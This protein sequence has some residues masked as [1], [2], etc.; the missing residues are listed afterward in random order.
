[1]GCQWVLNQAA[2][3]IVKGYT[4]CLA[5]CMALLTL[6]GSPDVAGLE[7]N[8][9]GPENWSG[10]SDASPSFNP[11]D[12][13]R[14]REVN[15]EHLP[16]RGDFSGVL[17]YTYQNFVSSVDG[18]RCQHYPT[19][20]HFAALALRTK[21]IRSLGWIFD[22]IVPAHG[23]YGYEPVLFKDR[24]YLYDPLKAHE[25]KADS[26][27]ELDILI[28][29]ASE[30]L[31][32]ED[33]SLKI[34]SR[35]SVLHGE[36]T[37]PKLTMNNSVEAEFADHLFESG[38]FYRAITEYRRL[39][40]AHRGQGQ[41]A[42]RYNL[43][44]NEGLWRAKRFEAALVGYTKLN[45]SKLSSQD[46]RATRLAIAK[47]LIAMGQPEKG[48]KIL[49]DNIETFEP[50]TPLM[51]ENLWSLALTLELLSQYDTEHELA[52]LVLSNAS[53]KLALSLETEFNSVRS[54]ELFGER[55]KRRLPAG[56]LAILPGAGYL[57]LNRPKAAL[58][59]LLGTGILG[60]ATVLSGIKQNWG[61]TLVF[62]LATLSFYSATIMGS[63]H[64]ASQF[65]ENLQ[66]RKR[67]YLMEIYPGY[68]YPRDV[69]NSKPGFW[70]R[71]RSAP[72][73]SNA[74]E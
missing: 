25:G 74:I 58:L 9:F 50:S 53:T 5:A 3:R 8:S 23:S 36:T 6:F 52:R 34:L 59:S 10:D 33:Y 61:S 63:I 11:L 46:R 42:L 29:K 64:G 2:R 68:A 20:S 22:R 14:P 39:L 13:K 47:L 54:T 45:Q 4:T 55:L 73:D 18:V 70:K 43:A 60:S 40:F 15:P 62:G 69:E 35:R 72:T 30:T 7:S 31:T 38:D 17:F 24:P 37:P 51:D 67:G 65:N 1:M 28:S 19:C 48:L 49:R 27:E 16:S 66:D 21:G 71:L 57:Y 12:S 41:N 56:S 44:I 32:K 26:D